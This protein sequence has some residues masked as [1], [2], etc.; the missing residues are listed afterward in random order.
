MSGK[1]KIVTLRQASLL[2]SLLAR[3]MALRVA[4]PMTTNR[5]ISYEVLSVRV[6]L[7]N[8][9]RMNLSLKVFSEKMNK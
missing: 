8:P 1:P 6:D 2:V 7:G 3:D 9:V 4:F 5:K